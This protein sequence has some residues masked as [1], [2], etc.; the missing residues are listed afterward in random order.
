MQ[1][2]HVWPWP[3]GKARQGWYGWVGKHKTSCLKTPWILREKHSASSLALRHST[4]KIFTKHEKLPTFHLEYKTPDSP[5]ELEFTPGVI[6]EHRCVFRSYRKNILNLVL[7][8]LTNTCQVL[9]LHLLYALDQCCINYYIILCT[10]DIYHNLTLAQAVVVM[11]SQSEGKNEPHL[12]WGCKDHPQLKT[13][14]G[15]CGGLLCHMAQQQQQLTLLLDKV[16]QNI[17]IWAS[18]SINRVQ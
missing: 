16:E 9:C 5:T 7:I 4:I 14:E 3:N 11:V 6:F 13:L 8:L 17:V 10:K 15:L 1:K 12:W 2:L 18:W